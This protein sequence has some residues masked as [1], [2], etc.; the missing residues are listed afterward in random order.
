MAHGKRIAMDMTD[1]DWVMHM[2]LISKE[3]PFAKDRI[4]DRINV[5]SRYPIHPV[6]GGFCGA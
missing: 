4:F 2:E 3:L 5:L 6:A 1:I